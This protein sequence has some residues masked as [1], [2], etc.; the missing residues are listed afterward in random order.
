MGLGKIV[1]TVKTLANDPKVQQH[2][3]SEKAEQISD[4]VLDK[5]AGA[6]NKV[7][8]GKHEEKITRARDAA[9][10]AIGTDDDPDARPGSAPKQ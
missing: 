8:G 7:T 2:L 1:K 10:R 5:A 3:K 6:A 9:D 4:S